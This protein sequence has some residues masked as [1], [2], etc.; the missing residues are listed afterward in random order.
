MKVQAEE[1]KADSKVKPTGAQDDGIIDSE[2][3]SD[4]QEYMRIDATHRQVRQQKLEL[5]AQKLAEAAEEER[6]RQ[7]EREAL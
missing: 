4:E 3:D 5:D 6:R 1:S 7:A 2:S